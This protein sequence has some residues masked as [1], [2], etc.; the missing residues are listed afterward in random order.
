MNLKNASHTDSATTLAAGFNFSRR[1]EIE[2]LRKPG[3]FRHGFTVLQPGKCFSFRVTT[4]RL[5]GRKLSPPMKVLK[6]AASTL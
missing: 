3:Y 5:P 6:P 2:L 4:A 1:Q